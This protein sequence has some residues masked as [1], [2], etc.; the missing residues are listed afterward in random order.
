MAGTVRQTPKGLQTVK[1]I[2]FAWTSSAGGAADATTAK[3]YDGKILGLATIPG[4]G[5]VAPTADYDVRITDADGLDVLLGAGID[6]HTTNTEYVDGATLSAV[7]ES[8]LTLA[9]TNAG[10]AKEGTAVLWIR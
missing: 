10:N 2:T 1:K 9:V 6:R 8:A 5:G 3:R 4:A 7:A